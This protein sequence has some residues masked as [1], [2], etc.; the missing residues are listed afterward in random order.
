MRAD[1]RLAGRTP[2]IRRGA[3]RGVARRLRAKGK[4]AAAHEPTKVD[5]YPARRRRGRDPPGRRRGRAG[6]AEGGDGWWQP[7]NT[8]VEQSLFRLDDHGAHVESLTALG[9]GENTQPRKR[10]SRPCFTGGARHTDDKTL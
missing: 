3:F 9:R 5:R 2:H 4:R 10:L 8:W 7:E 6:P 1:P